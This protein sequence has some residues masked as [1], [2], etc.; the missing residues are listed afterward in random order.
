[1]KEPYE[2]GVA[3]HLDPA[4]TVPGTIPPLVAPAVDRPGR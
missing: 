2:E 4:I 1:M 3:G